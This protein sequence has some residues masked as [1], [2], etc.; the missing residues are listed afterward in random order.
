MRSLQDPFIKT[1]GTFGKN[2]VEQK[3]FIIFLGITEVIIN[4]GYFLS[5]F[6]DF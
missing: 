5:F 1:D 4:G 2:V 6:M 3:F